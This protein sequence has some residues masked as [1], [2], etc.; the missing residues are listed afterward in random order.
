MLADVIAKLKKK[1][2][3]YVSSSEFEAKAKGIVCKKLF[4]E[5]QIKVAA[6]ELN[7]MESTCSSGGM[8]CTIW[9]VPMGNLYAEV[10]YSET[11]EVLQISFEKKYS[12]PAFEVIA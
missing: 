8:S 12:S 11:Y 9:G 10:D 5:Y 3:C 4:E 1:D 6:E 2:K 7:I